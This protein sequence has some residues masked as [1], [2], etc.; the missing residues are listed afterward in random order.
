MRWQ[1]KQERKRIARKAKA[2]KR[3]LEARALRCDAVEPDAALS[4]PS[5]SLVAP[6]R[7]L[8]PST[9][10]L[11]LLTVSNLLVAFAL[12]ASSCFSFAR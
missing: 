8:V 3:A 12:G 11:H 1:T 2:R 6:L 5:T 10:L 7:G 4:S 9:T